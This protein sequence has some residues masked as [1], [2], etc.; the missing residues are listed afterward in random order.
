MV[1]QKFIAELNELL[2]DQH[3]TINLTDEAFGLLVERGWDNKMGARPMSRAID[4]LIKVPLS[5]MILKNR[6]K[7]NT[8]IAVDRDNNSMLFTFGVDYPVT[9]T[10]KQ[11]SDMD[12]E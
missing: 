1:A 10:L 9:G 2:I 8:L 6:P 12:V 11:T 4:E 3:L 7:T 5:R